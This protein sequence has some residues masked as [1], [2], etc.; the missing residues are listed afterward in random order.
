M[1]V[2]PKPTRRQWLC[3]K[4]AIVTG[5]SSGIGRAIALALAAQGAYLALAARRIDLLHTLSAEVQALG[6][7]AIALKTDVTCQDD[8]DHLVQQTLHRWQRIDILV[9][10][11]GQYIRTP[12][13]TLALEDVERSMDINFFS[14]VRQVLAVLPAMRRQGREHIVL[15]SSVDA[16]KPI[17]PDIPYAS[18][19]FALSGFGDLLRQE[20]F[21]SGIEV[22]TVF[23]GRVDT[24]MIATLDVPTISAKIPA[25][26]VA[27]ATL[28][29]ILHR[30]AEVILPPQARLL[31]Y[32]NV[33]A[34]R[35]ADWSVRFFKLHGH[36]SY[37][38]GDKPHDLA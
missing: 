7:A 12:L 35:L 2:S 8:I 32:L 25:E 6:S 1:P 37:S 15:M 29:G 27:R 24:P 23:P 17:P 26:A 16:K 20:L 11:A 34:P 9:A 28:N 13:S 5:A 4:V 30:K 22:T 18:A 14:I 36:D 38:E 21:G 19:K 31:H 33:F 3:E 10:N